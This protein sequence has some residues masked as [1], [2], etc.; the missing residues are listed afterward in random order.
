MTITGDFL[1]TKKTSI[2]TDLF[3]LL[4]GNVLLS[5]GETPN[6]HRRESLTSVF[7]FRLAISGESLRQL[8]RSDPHVPEKRTFRSSLSALPRPSCFSQASG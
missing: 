8:V 4:P 3:I 5:Q 2:S 7:G 1:T 6:Y